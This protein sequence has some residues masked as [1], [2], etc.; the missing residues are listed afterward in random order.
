M[1]FGILD[2]I[3]RKQMREQTG[4]LFNAQK[5]LMEALDDAADSIEK[6][7]EKVSKSQDNLAKE[8]R[9]HGIILQNII[10][11]LKLLESK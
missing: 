6:S 4:K 3:I 7:F 11:E 2:S 10:K 5:D 9:A 1:G 8:M